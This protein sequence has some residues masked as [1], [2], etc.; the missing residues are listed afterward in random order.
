LPPPTCACTAASYGGEDND[1]DNDDNNDNDDDD[2]DD[3][4]DDDNDDNDD[5]DE[6]N[7]DN[8]DDDDDDDDDND[9]NDD[10]D[11]GND[12]DDNNNNGGGLPWTVMA[13]ADAAALDLILATTTTATTTAK[14]AILPFRT[15]PLLAVAGTTATRCRGCGVV[16]GRPMEEGGGHHCRN[17]DNAEEEGA[18][19]R[20]NEDDNGYQCGHHRGGGRGWWRCWEGDRGGASTSA[21]VVAVSIVDIGR[22]RRQPSS[23]PSTSSRP[24]SWRFGCRHR[25]LLASAIVAA[26]NEWDIWWGA[27]IRSREACVP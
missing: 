24:S 19:H 3:D 7:E 25:P 18:H 9:D 4:N 17:D 10:D 12:D 26:V 8:E 13:D 27:L 14:E 21:I 23:R 6:D 2:D 5:E 15:M 11:D 20:Q 22:H 16:G 1:E